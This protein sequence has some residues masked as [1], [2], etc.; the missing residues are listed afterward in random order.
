MKA[1]SDLLGEARR[2]LWRGRGTA[3]LRPE[4]GSVHVVG[5]LD[6]VSLDLRHLPGPGSWGRRWCNAD[7]SDRHVKGATC[8]LTSRIRERVVTTHC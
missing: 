6:N 3:S 2:P 4:Q 7:G 5:P 8:C 1:S